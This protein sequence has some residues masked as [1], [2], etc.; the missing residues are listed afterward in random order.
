[1]CNWELHAWKNIT[2]LVLRNLEE[3]W[4]IR[5]LKHIPILSIFGYIFPFD[6]AW[7]NFNQNFRRFL[8]VSLTI[9][10]V[11]S[12]VLGYACGRSIVVT[13]LTLILVLL[14]FHQQL[15]DRFVWVFFPQFKRLGFWARKNNIHH[16]FYYIFSPSLDVVASNDWHVNKK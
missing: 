7:K 2:M 8:M 15:C 9:G 13:C 12:T 1:M 10:N 5:Y 3:K 6:K 14:K 16:P 11:M 4:D